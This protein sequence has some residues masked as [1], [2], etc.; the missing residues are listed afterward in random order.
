MKVL[1]YFSLAL[2]CVVLSFGCSGCSEQQTGASDDQP[3]GAPS[4]PTD[5]MTLFYEL[6]EQQAGENPR[7][8]VYIVAHRANTRAGI[9]QRLPE[10]SLEI[11][12]V[13]IES[14]VVDMIE[15]DV[16][17]TKDDV[18]VL[19][20][21]ASVA[22]TTNGTKNVS[23]MTY[24]EIRQLDMNREDDKVTTGIKVPTLKEVFELCKG[25]MF[26]NLDIHNKNV[27][28]GQLAALIK[29]CGM[30]DQVM[31]Y[32]KKDELVEYQNID[33][34]ILIHPYVSTVAAA[35]EYKQYPGAMLFQYGLKYDQDSDNFAREMRAAG[36]LTYTNI[37]NYDKHML[38]GNNTYL[39]KFVNSETDFIQTDYAEMVHEYLDVE[40]LR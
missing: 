29:E 22:R 1:R 37:L 27:P 28:V 24:A 7:E 40:G 32:S 23:D 6:I 18:L 21:D 13:A 15:V 9:N 20:H 36:C 3:T 16:R 19:M 14:G 30:T 26:I 34:N 25:K 10:N 2:V 39:Q 4:R 11:I 8:R 35:N 17:P 31:I 12:Q 38:S 5:L 33:P